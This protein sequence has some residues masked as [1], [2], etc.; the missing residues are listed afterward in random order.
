MQARAWRW[1]LGLVLRDG[2][3]IE[4]YAAEGK[5]EAMWSGCHGTQQGDPAK[6]ADVL[7]KIADMDN[8]PKQ[9]VTGRD[10]L[11]VVKL[12]LE[13][14]LVELRAF[15]DLSKSTDGSF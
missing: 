6:L 8:P 12:A 10:A 9:F 4:D 1:H 15:E 11:G 7:V 5:A 13:A 3:T 14:R 2:S